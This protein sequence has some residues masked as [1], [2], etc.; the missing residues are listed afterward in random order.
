MAEAATKPLTPAERGRL[1]AE[2]RWADHL[3]TTIRLDSLSGPQRQLV[4]AL[5]AAARSQRDPAA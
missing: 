3:P 1:G 2:R 5:I 4:V